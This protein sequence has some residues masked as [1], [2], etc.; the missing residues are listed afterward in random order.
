MRRLIKPLFW[1]L[2]FTVLLIIVDQILIQVPP[3]HPAHASV[4]RFYSDFRT[5][6]L[7]LPL[8]PTSAKPA[9]PSGPATPTAA[10]SI[11]AIIGQ[12]QI[13]AT[14][15]APTAAQQAQRYIYANEKGE[16][17]FADTLKEIPLEYRGTAEPLGE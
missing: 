12:Q 13:K 2:V 9:K 4:V 8:K 5:R 15:P 16:L 6:L 17:Q 14:A 11:E 7:G 10:Q 1:G 3:V